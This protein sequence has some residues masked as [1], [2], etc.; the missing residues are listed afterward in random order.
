MK[1]RQAYTYSLLDVLAADSYA[2]IA[3]HKRMHQVTKMYQGLHAIE[4][5]QDPAAEDWR[6]LADAVNLT[7][8]LV[9]MGVLQDSEGLLIDAVQAL[10][11]AAR[12]W[13]DLG[14]LRLNARGIAAVRAVMED[15]TAALQ[16]LPERT[17]ILAHR[18][19]EKR[20]RQV[21]KGKTRPGDVVGVM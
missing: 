21:L 12:R 5:G 15:Y 1:R 16:Q 2:P 19:T 18:A 7:E 14:A 11:E 9:D 17:I 8:T 10:S 20:L 4:R 6:M 3:M 13:R